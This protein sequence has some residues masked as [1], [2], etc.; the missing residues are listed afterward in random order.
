M[1]ENPFDQTHARPVLH[2]AL[3][4]TQALSVAR[5]ARRERTGRRAFATLAFPAALAD[6]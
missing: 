3:G 4:R 2:R 6:V 1:I 5:E